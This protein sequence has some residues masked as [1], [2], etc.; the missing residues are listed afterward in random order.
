M[1]P[2]RVS[3]RA[4]ARLP[5]HGRLRPHPVHV[6]F[7]LL[8]VGFVGALLSLLGGRT[9]VAI[10]V[11]ALVLL[12]AAT[13]PLAQLETGHAD[14]PLAFLIAAGAAGLARYLLTGA[15][16]A[17]HAAAAF[18]GAGALTK[19]EASL[20]A[21]SALVA[22]AIAVMAGERRQLRSIGRAAL[23]VLA[24]A[25]PWRP[26]VVAHLAP[27]DYSFS[28]LLDPTYLTDHSDRVRI[29]FLGDA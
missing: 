18:L 13:M 16:F 1:L 3:I 24:I 4:S 6:Q 10:V 25:M 23:V 28:G 12:F 20:F 21:L 19:S 11:S 9:P 29:S 17:L 2:A 14:M 26:W 8:A 22:A 5:C 15:P 27:T 7:A